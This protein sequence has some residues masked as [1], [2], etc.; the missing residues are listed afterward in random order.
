[1]RPPEI[2]LY[3]L[4][5]IFIAIGI[6]LGMDATGPTEFGYARAALC[7]AGFISIGLTLWWFYQTELTSAVALMLFF[8]VG[9]IGTALVGGLKWLDLKENTFCYIGAIL[10]DMH[11]KGPYVLAAWGNGPYPT[12]NVKITVRNVKDAFD[13]TPP[14]YELGDVEPNM[15]RQLHNVP[16]LPGPGTYQIDIHARS[17]NFQ[18]I[19]TIDWDGKMA[20]QKT[21]V[22][23]ITIEGNRLVSTLLQ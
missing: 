9:C 6:A 1:V 15:A 2:L 8:T 21:E 4:F 23:R 5:P 3:V 11:N 12:I 19:L 18:E 14:Y 10:G 20:S 13:S 7:L 17:G 16:P 22:R